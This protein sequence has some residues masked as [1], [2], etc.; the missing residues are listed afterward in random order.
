MGGQIGC[1][2]WSDGQT[3][4]NAFWLTLP[5]EVIVSSQADPPPQ[6]APEEPV[7]RIPLRLPPRTRILVAEDVRA[8]Q[9][10]A[11]ALLR[12]VGHMVD[13]ASN[14][15]EAIRAVQRIP[16]DIVFMDIFMPGM[17]GQEATRHIRE[18]PGIA[19]RIP[20][21]ALTANTAP[22]DEV[23]FLA[24]GMNGVLSKPVSLAAL[25]TALVRHVWQGHPA[26]GP[27]P[28]KAPPEI[29]ADET[30]LSME[31]IKELR[32]NLPADVLTNL[33]EECLKDLRDRMPSFRRVLASG[34]SA[35]IESQAHTIAGVA[36]G[37]GLA[38]LEAKSRAIMASAKARDTS[39]FITA[40]AETEAELER[41]SAA[42]L[43]ILRKRAA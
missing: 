34:D 22:E 40:F 43:E 15:D 23:L 27:P 11:A 41:G 38:A 35:E 29:E 12:R 30:I 6:R 2:P 31:R 42:L 18:L 16:Y 5:A 17:S 39:A 9:I 32:G 20:I 3:E 21:V 14:G 33:I 10:V 37:Y 8:N 24:A 36:G 1:E 26:G 25:Q 4:G 13:I 19:G 7:E 28:A